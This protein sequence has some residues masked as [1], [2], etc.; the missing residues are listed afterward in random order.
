MSVVNVERVNGNGQAV[1]F[2]LS[3][4]IFIVDDDAAVRDSLAFVFTLAGYR[5]R[6]F[7]D[8]ASFVAAARAA[9]PACVLLDV[10]MPQ[11]SGIDVLKQIDASSYPAPIFMLS[12]RGDI[13]TAIESIRRGAF[14]FFEKRADVDIMVA[15]VTETVE[16]WDRRGVNADLPAA[17]PLSFP[18]SEQL[19]P[20]EREVLGQVMAGLCN[21]EAA[22]N[23][24]IS[25]R[26]VEAHRAHVMLKLG[27]RN[28][29]EL[30]RKV[31]DR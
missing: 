5:V 2:G 18:G 26:T 11:A 17:L 6:T 25:Q 7:P 27:A 24:G 21:R 31:M 23:L 16:A 10:Y 15:R 28:T 20:R 29:A 30:V 1:S 3:R 9:V 19:T 14:D 12:G 22:K 8:G 13:P 4:E